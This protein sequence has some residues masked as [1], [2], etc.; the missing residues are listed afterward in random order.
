MQVLRRPIL[1][2]GVEIGIHQSQS[3]VR[4][5]IDIRRSPLVRQGGEVDLVHA[6]FQ[7]LCAQPGQIAHGQVGVYILIENFG[8]IVDFRQDIAAWLT[9]MPEHE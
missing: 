4:D 2:I 1:H 9:R 6:H 3:F 7:N 5:Q 8:V